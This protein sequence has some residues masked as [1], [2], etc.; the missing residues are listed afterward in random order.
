M[1]KEA[2]VSYEVAKLLKEK[3][4][5]GYTTIFSSRMIG[6]GICPQ[7]VAMA[8]LRE[9]HDIFID[10][11]YDDLDFYWL[12]ESIAADVP[13]QDRPKLLKNGTA[14]HRTYEEA[15]EAALKYCLEELL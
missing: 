1:I 5:D 4:F 10:V 9:V 3:G 2:F 11:G 15:V 13:V 8:W 12:V 6:G 7:S 14:C